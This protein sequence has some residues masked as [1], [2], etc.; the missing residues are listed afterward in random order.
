MEDQLDYIEEMASVLDDVS[1]GGNA[2][3]AAEKIK[4]L[5]KEGDEFMERKKELF[6][7]A[8]P[9]ALDKLTKKYAKRSQESARMLMLSIQKLEKSG[10]ATPELKDAIL[11]M[12]SG[13]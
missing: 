11:N 1:E 9:E 5:G 4:A 2:S 8:D 10:R 12:K 6:A 13:Q 3:D 7:D